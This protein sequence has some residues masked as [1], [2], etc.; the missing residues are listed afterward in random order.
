MENL[1]IFSP[2]QQCP[3][4]P[5]LYFQPPRS[6]ASPKGK[7][8]F[9]KTDLVSRQKFRDRGQLCTRETSQRNKQKWTEQYRI[10]PAHLRTFQ[11]PFKVDLWGHR[12][13]RPGTRHPRLFK[14]L[15]LQTG[16]V[17]ERGHTNSLIEGHGGVEHL[18]SAHIH[19]QATY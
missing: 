19:L 3:T 1:Q 12:Q 5:P 16:S 13:Q 14:D 2:N 9:Y 18:H 15:W 7:P 6:K 17:R 11:M 8:A 10:L 4:H